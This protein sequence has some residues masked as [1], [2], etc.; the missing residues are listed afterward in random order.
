[1]VEGLRKLLKLD[2]QAGV[3]RYWADTYLHTGQTWEQEIEKA[4]AR[5]DVFLLLL[6]PNFMASDYIY[7]TE[8]PKIEDRVRDHGGLISPVLMRDCVWEHKLGRYQAV[9]RDK[10]RLRP[11]DKWRPHSD[12]HVAAYRQL[13]AAMRDRWPDRFGAPA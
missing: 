10:I 13:S 3:V 11:I 7:K 1:M 4:I 9:P 2:E 8:L 5:A 12:G 6:T